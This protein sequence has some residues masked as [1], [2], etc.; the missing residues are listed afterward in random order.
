LKNKI[1]YKKSVFKDL[2]RISHPHR[3]KLIDHIEKELSKDPYKGKQLTGN[4]KGLFGLRS[5]D[6]RIIY[7]ILPERV[8]ILRISHRKDVYN[9]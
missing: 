1:D 4:F 2:K 8:L 9:D 3:I 7:T 5:G 6:Y